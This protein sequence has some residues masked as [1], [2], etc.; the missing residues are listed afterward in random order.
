MAEKIAI[1]TRPVL[2]CAASSH[3]RHVRL[4]RRPGAGLSADTMINTRLPSISCWVAKLKSY[5]L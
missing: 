2:A 5:P 1:A 3:D 4:L